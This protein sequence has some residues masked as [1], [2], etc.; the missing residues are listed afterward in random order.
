MKFLALLSG[1]WLP[2]EG[3]LDGARRGGSVLV[4]HGQPHMVGLLSVLVLHDDLVVASVLL[5][6]VPEINTKLILIYSSRS[7]FA[8]D[9]QVRSKLIAPKIL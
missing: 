9:R 2:E 8:A 1:A 7:Q 3:W 5:G 6:Q 4:L